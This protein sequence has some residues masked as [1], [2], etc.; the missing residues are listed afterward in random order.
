MAKTRLNPIGHSAPQASWLRGVGIIALWLLLPALHGCVGYYA[1][2]L[3]GHLEI[4]RERESVERLK[5]SRETPP[6]LRADMQTASAVRAFAVDELALPDNRSYR[7]YVDLGRDYVTISVFAAP[8]FSTLPALQCFP[9]FG[10]VPYQAYFDREDAFA[11]A[12]DLQDQG[13]DVH[14]TGVI[15]YSTLGW[16]ADPLLNTMFSGDE[17]RLAGIVFHE[18]AHQQVYL[19]NDSG[20]NEAYAVAVEIEGVKAWLRSTGNEAAIDTYLEDLSRRDQF[21]EL[22]SETR[23]DLATIYGTDS[24]DDAK[25]AQKTEAIA[26]LRSRYERVKAREWDG[27]SGYDGWFESPINNAKLMAVGVY[28][29]L[30]PA[31]RGL[32]EICDRDFAKFHS[33]VA[34]V[35]RLDFDARRAFLATAKSC[36]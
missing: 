2:S 14:V 22:V 1:S 11:R 25:R 16:T 28:N 32:F 30:V 18:L 31:F 20:F 12:R 27:F 9:F 6:E 5:T 36:G 34:K 17:A 26:R 13:L 33:T 21:V 7:S 15:A 4:L 8:E 3:N 23:D 29:D 10:C 35:G 19:R 24:S